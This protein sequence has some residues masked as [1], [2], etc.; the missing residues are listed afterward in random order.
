[1][2]ENKIKL[3]KNKL[4]SI[5]FKEIIPSEAFREKIKNIDYEFNTTSITYNIYVFL[6]VGGE[7]I[8][9]YTIDE[10]LDYIENTNPFKTL[11]RKNKISKLIN[12]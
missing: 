3:L 4:I 12:G 9:R 6:F 5:G 11:I 7:L 10:T 2:K 1:M 8:F